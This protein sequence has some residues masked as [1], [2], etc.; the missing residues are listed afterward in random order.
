[1]DQRFHRTPLFDMMKSFSDLI[2]QGDFVGHRDKFIF[3]GHKDILGSGRRRKRRRRKI[4]SCVRP[5]EAK[6]ITWSKKAKLSSFT[7]IYSCRVTQAKKDLRG[8][9]FLKNL[10]K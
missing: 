10:K 6:L 5:R 3:V 9:T 1:M 4:Y 7:P 8:G 2:R